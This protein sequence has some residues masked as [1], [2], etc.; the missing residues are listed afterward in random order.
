MPSRKLRAAVLPAAALLLFAA[1][2]PP[3]RAQD[4]GSPPQPS[5][6]AQAKRDDTNLELHLHMLLASNAEGQRGE[7]PRE[8]EGVVRQLKASLPYSQ[9]RLVTTFL[10]RVKD[11][12]NTLEVSSVGPSLLT[13]S[14]AQQL[15][16]PTFYQFSVGGVR[17]A[18]GASGQTFVQ[19]PR[20]R[21][22]LRVPVQTAAVAPAAG[23]A[24]GY[25]VIQYENVG[26]TTDFSAR[27]GE[28]TVV[29][30]LTTRR[31]DEVFVVVFT[32][33]RAA[34]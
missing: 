2:A 28:P 30:T 33:R 15:T 9:H 23:D 7:V 12:G 22:T 11:G 6:G 21:F 25:P 32:I 18:E 34:R 17:L 29:G 24:P 13:Q 3:A 19:V 26:M 8:L 10:H 31:P 1:L 16:A 27:E 5:R 4:E 14:Q 20:F